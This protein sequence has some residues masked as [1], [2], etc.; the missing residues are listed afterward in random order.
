MSVAKQIKEKLDQAVG[1]EKVNVIVDESG[2]N[3]VEYNKQ[4]SALEWTILLKGEDDTEATK[5]AVS[6]AGEEIKAAFE[7]HLPLDQS[8]ATQQPA[9]AAPAAEVPAVAQ[10]PAAQVP[11]VAPALTAH[12]S[13]GQMNQAASVPAT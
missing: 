13:A 5:T 4:Q 10:V 1:P 2:F 6:A 3:N 11:A 7:K 8:N 9:A 12:T